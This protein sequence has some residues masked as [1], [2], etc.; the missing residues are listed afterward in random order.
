MRK[1]LFIVILL[2]ITF[3]LPSHAVLKEANLDTTLYILRVE[4]T[5]YHL[6][7]ERQSKGMQQRQKQIEAELRSIMNQANQ[8]AI[9]LYSQKSGYI[10]DLTYA[11]HE[12]T[13]MFKKFKSKSQPFRVMIQKNNTEVARFD[14]LI[15]DLN[16]MPAQFMR[17]DVRKSRDICLTLAV[18]IRRQL[19]ENQQQL[20]DYVSYYNLTEKHLKSL[21]DYANQRYAEIQENIFRNGGDSY[22][23]ILKNLRTRLQETGESINEKYKMTMNMRSQWDVKIIFIL[24]TIIFFYGLVSAALNIFTMRIVITRL[25]K[26]GKFA[27]QKEAFMAKRT[28]ITMAMSVVTFAVI[29]GILQMTISQ[30]FLLMA[31]KL[32]VEYT[33]LLAVILISLLL[34]VD[35]NQIKS[36]FRIYSPLMLVGFIVIAFRIVLIPNDLV[37][38]IF[39]PV[40]VI[41]SVWQYSVIRRHNYNVPKTDMAYTYISLAVF[42]I[43]VVCSWVGFTLFSVQLLIWWVMQL[44]F[45][46]TITCLRDW[47]MVVQKRKGYEQKPITKTWL[48]NLV[49]QVLMPALAVCSFVISIYWAADV[50]NMSDTTWRIFNTH[51]VNNKEAITLSVANISVVFILFFFFSYLNKTA[52]AITR[53]HFEQTDPSTALSKSVMSRNVIQILAWGTWLL[54]S[55]RIFNVNM[56]AI[57]VISGGLSTGIGF[58]MKDILENI[59][60]GA[61]LMAGRIKVGD[62]IECDG[63]TGKVCSISYTS[64]TIETIYGSIISFQNSQLFTKN[65]KNLTKNHGYEL[66]VVQ[67]GVAYGSDIALCKDILVEAVGKLKA[68]RRGKPVKVMVKGF[69]DNSVDLKVLAWVPVLT[70]SQCE[71]DILEC[72]YQTLNEHHIEIPFPQRDIHI[73]SPS[74]NT[75][76]SEN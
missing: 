8:N 65:Y 1:N 22:I 76:E 4:L 51:F 27:G 64:T 45:I 32:L 43:S 35:G 5:N 38:L 59:Y 33:W 75:D 2:L 9:M 20:Q 63:T 72:I 19:K 21:N 7:L 39:P 47:L 41:C 55:L 74:E 42:I 66:D 50:F 31:G 54:V 29:L 49:Y 28:C 23:T 70:K 53:F 15:N 16:M 48:F 24:F 17:E 13:D 6:D 69:G 34:R 3:A 10:F 25:M 30:N 52:Q 12:A 56:T 36:A 62:Y 44:T 11:C 18:N 37:N 60:Y 61:S 26:K 68:I 67:V 14:S 46:L 73:I 58:A 57:A 71:S 40:L